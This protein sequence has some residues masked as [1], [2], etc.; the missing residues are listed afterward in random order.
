MRCL[1]SQID[2]KYLRFIP[3]VVFIKIVVPSYL[4]VF[5]TAYEIQLWFLISLGTQYLSLLEV[6]AVFMSQN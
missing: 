4:Q 6:N 2:L 1:K 3:N 5:F